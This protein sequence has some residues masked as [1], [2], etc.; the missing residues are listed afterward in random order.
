MVFA[1]SSEAFPQSPRPCSGREDG[2]PPAGRRR[3]GMVD[4]T[5][6]DP[7]FPPHRIAGSTSGRRRLVKYSVWEGVGFLSGA[8]RAKAHPRTS[9]AAGCWPTYPLCGCGGSIRARLRT[10]LACPL[11]CRLSGE[12]KPVHYECPSCGW[13]W[14]EGFVVK[15]P[16]PCMRCGEPMRLMRSPVRCLSSRSGNT[17]RGNAKAGGRPK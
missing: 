12:G 4:A 8:R 11:A 10:G 1:A 9:T 2:S 14:A 7:W 13:T 3:R 17:H 16:P 15:G 5:T 6:C